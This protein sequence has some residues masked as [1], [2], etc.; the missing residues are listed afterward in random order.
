MKY[1][2]IQSLIIILITTTSIGFSQ[3][4]VQLN[5]SQNKRAVSPESI[6][7]ENILP[8]LSITDFKLHNAIRN[9]EINKD[10]SIIFNFEDFENKEG[11]VIY[12]N[13]DVNNVTS[14]IVKF[15]EYQFAQAIITVHPSEYLI[16][17]DIP[18]LKKQYTTLISSNRQEYYLAELDAEYLREIRSCA[19][20]SLEDDKPVKNKSSNIQNSDQN[21]IN[22]NSSEN[23]QT[24]MTNTAACNSPGEDDPADIKVLIIYTPTSLSYSGS[25]AGMNTKI[26]QAIARAN[27]ASI[28]SNLGMNFIL[29]H[30]EVIGYTEYFGDGSYKSSNDLIFIENDTYVQQLRNT[31]AA[32][33]VH[34]IT[35]DGNISG[36]AKLLE[37]QNGD[38]NAVFGLTRVQVLDITD[39]FTHEI[40]HNMGAMHSTTQNTQPGPTIW[41]DWPENG[42]SAGSRFIGNDSNYYTSIMSYNQGF[43]YS[44]GNNATPISYFSTPLLNFQGQA[45][46]DALTAD[47]TKTLKTLKHIYSKYRDET[48]LLY[49]SANSTPILAPGS[50][51][52]IT[53]VS[54]NNVPNTSTSYSNSTN[55]IASRYTDYSYLKSC[56]SKGST[57]P[58]SVDV[59][60]PASIDAVEV[61]VWIDYNNDFDFDDPGELVFNSGPTTPGVTDNTSFPYNP[62]NNLFSFFI[63]PPMTAFTGEVR[64]RIRYNDLGFTTSNSTPCGDSDRGEVEDYT[65][66]LLE[67][68]ECSA[69]SSFAYFGT[70]NIEPSSASLSWSLL[71]N[72]TYDLRYRKIGNI[73]WTVFENIS[74]AD[75]TLTELENNTEYE[76]QIRSQCS[77]GAL[78]PY[79]DSLLFTTRDIL[80]YCDAASQIP[81][82]SDLLNEVK[83]SLNTNE[84][85]S[86]TMDYSINPYQAYIDYTAQSIL[87]SRGNT[88]GFEAIAS[89]SEYNQEVIVWIDFNQDGDFDDNDEQLLRTITGTSP[90]TGNIAIPTSAPT[91]KTRM[92]IRLNDTFPEPE[93]LAP[94][95]TPCGNSGYGQV[96]DYTVVIYDDYLYYENAWVPTSPS[97]VSLETENILVVDGETSITATTSANVVTIKPSSKL[98][99]NEDVGFTI[100]GDL[101]NGG[102]LELNSISNSYSSLI[103]NGNVSGDVVYKRYINSAATSGTTTGNNDLVSAPVTGQ[104]FGDFRAANN[105]ILTGTIG[106]GPILYLF[107]PFDTVTNVF[108]NFSASDDA[109]ILDAGVGYRTGSTN[110]STYTFLGT[111]ETGSRTVAI[112]APAGGSKWNLIGNPYPSYINSIE[113]LNANSV[114]G[115]LDAEATAIYGY[116]SNTYAGNDSTVGNY[117]IINNVSNSDLNIAPGQ[118]FF[119]ASSSTGGNVQ[120]TP[121]MRTTTG[122][123]D[124]ILGRSSGPNYSFKIGLISDVT[125]TTS[126]Y[127]NEQSSL[128]LDI[129]YDA[130]V[131]GSDSSDYPIYSHLVEDNTGRP[132][133][134]QSLNHTDLNN[135]SIPLGINANM[136]EQL[137]FSLIESNIPNDVDVY[138]EDT[139]EQSFTL[140][141]TS[142]FIL[143]PGSDLSGTGRFYLHI[144]N[145]TLPTSEFSLE[146]IQIYNPQLGNE[147]MVSGT[148]NED[149]DSFIYDMQGRLVQQKVL[150]SRLSQQAINVEQLS[151][152]V[153]VIVLKNKRQSKTQKV[154]LR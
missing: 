60:T 49:C 98:L 132:I 40:G 113:F 42:W 110:A 104:S 107:G 62:A 124:F 141:N 43:Y 120:F 32:D 71:N 65:L 68:E 34:I 47:N 97:G 80:N 95:D 82:A 51:G 154:I 133:A 12:K 140:L 125:H 89:Y 21:F 44:D 84:I 76:A 19:S 48:S 4:K 59:Y 7:S 109:T 115:S 9:N 123:D 13:K 94:N 117:T 58:I 103:V 38:D 106:G 55:K 46:G 78:S 35:R 66:V 92:R 6:G 129:G 17:I 147:I 102:T 90:W 149:T 61:L 53:N 70:Y 41:Y 39:T 57:H 152:G 3:N 2:H 81:E 116:N 25:Q 50:T 138:L 121:A 148:L 63:T 118:G 31:H 145:V 142:D 8:S 30:S 79:S 1:R 86:N 114:N 37:G 74:E 69:S 101:N 105:N 75:I 27:I 119:V 126:F 91:G 100:N 135:L 137:T 64:M 93:P 33:F 146:H 139:L 96:Q 15:E 127:F 83:L 130:A 14:Y 151:A 24:T 111:V 45:I 72:A 144:G 23:Y 150:T 143:T 77:D 26:A 108:I 128:G 87:L 22:K 52:A 5:V 85:F 11:K 20:S 73:A 10:D 36:I 99:I 88:Y 136:G 122:T 16:T 134:V 28:N 112:N 29:A 54:I 18:E 67:P 131:F 153:Y 56:L